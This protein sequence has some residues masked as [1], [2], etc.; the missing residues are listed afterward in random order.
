MGAQIYRFEVH[1]P[2]FGTT[3]VESIGPESAT[4]AAARKWNAE[5]REIAG[6]C[7]VRKL[8]KADK[9]RCRRCGKEFGEPGSPG[10]YCPDCVAILEQQRRERNRIRGT[11]RR[12]GMRE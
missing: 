2:D 8:G 11:D 3:I 9:P 12:A 10:A 7:G 1:H 6:Y 4:Q 5:W